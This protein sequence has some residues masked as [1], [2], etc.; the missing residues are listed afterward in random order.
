MC[1][2]SRSRNGEVP[3]EDK[4]RSSHDHD[5]TSP[6][7]KND[8]LLGAKIHAHGVEKL[9]LPTKPIPQNGPAVDPGCAIQIGTA[10]YDSFDLSTIT[11]KPETDRAIGISNITVKIGGDVE[12]ALPEVSLLQL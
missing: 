12:V 6:L 1:R 2:I 11:A 5:S 10:L 9:E 4:L 3:R 8:H 7:I